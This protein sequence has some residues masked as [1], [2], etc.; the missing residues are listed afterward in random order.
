MSA[1]I[2]LMTP[3]TDEECLIAALADVGFDRIAQ[4][5]HLCGQR[6]KHGLKLDLRRGDI[7]LANNYRVLHSRTAYEDDPDPALRRAYLGVAAGT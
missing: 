6:L 1:Y 4:F 5:F 2:T 7:Q 3:M